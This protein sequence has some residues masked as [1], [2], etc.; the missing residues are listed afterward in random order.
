MKLQCKDI[1]IF[2]LV[3]LKKGI[4]AHTFPFC[5]TLIMSINKSTRDTTTYA[6]VTTSY[7]KDGSLYYR[8][9]FTYKSKHISLGS[10]DNP[11]DAHRAYLSANL[12]VSSP[13][14]RIEDYSSIQV[15]PF[16][17][18]VVI[19]NFRDNDIYFSNPIYMRNK[20][21]SYYLSPQEELKFSIDDLFYYSSHKIMKRG[22]H[23][24]V[25]DYGMQV[26]IVSR[27]GI[28]PY[29]IRGRDYIQK[30]GD[31]YDYR[32]ENIEV[33]N[34]YHGVKY[35]THYN[36]PVYKASI[37]IK[38]NYT[39]GCYQSAL[40]AAIAYNKAIDILKSK[41]LNKSFMP[42]YIDNIPASMYADIYSKIEISDKIT[43]HIF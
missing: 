3:S 20:F 23:L 42:N 39:I 29:A 2:S 14:M 16:E 34:N 8:A 26:S 41:G 32:Y 33:L 7:K 40:E 10:F 38:G 6:G 1:Q 19:I 43:S 28:K 13:F 9:S 17:K 36:K 27:Y 15:L 24:F 22:G 25:A 4:F 11:T 35:T 21:F 37:H 31:E 12:L 5:Y 30:N 18:W